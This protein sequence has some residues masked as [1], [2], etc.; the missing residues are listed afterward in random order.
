MLTLIN[1]ERRANGLAELTWDGAAAAGLAHAQ[2]MARPGY[3]SHWNTEGYGPDHRYTLAGGLDAIRE[4]VYMY[5]HSAGAGP[6]T[7]DEWADLIQQAQRTLMESPGHRDNILASE[8]THIGI[9]IA[10]DADAGR[11]RIAQEFVDRYVT[12]QSIPGRASL[13]D[14]ITI[15]GR[16]SP[17]GSAPWLNLAYGPFPEPMGVA[18]LNTTGTY[19]S[20]AE[21]YQALPFT[22]E[23]DGRFRQQIALDHGGQLGLYHIR[24]W[25]DVSGISVLASDVI[26]EVIS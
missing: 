4:N 2:D 15:S 11:L 12:L 6:T 3:L 19:S 17:G 7:P 25:V 9:S 22:V 14:S 26:V 5:G 23:A 13:G 18:E 8:H 24:I 16:I 21:T 1:E 10:Y 20:S